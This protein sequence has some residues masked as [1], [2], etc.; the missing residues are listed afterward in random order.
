MDPFEK[1]ALAAKRAD[2][3]LETFMKAPAAGFALTDRFFSPSDNILALGD[4]L[5]FMRYLSEEKSLS[6]KIDFVYIDPPFFT[7]TGQMARVRLETGDANPKLL[8]RIAY[9]DSSSR[10]LE[11]YLTDLA[12]RLELIRDL[13]ADSGVVCVHL[14]WHAVH[15]VKLLM[16]G[17]FGSANFVNE[18]IWS[19][20]SG[21]FG[22]RGFAKKHDTILVYAKTKKYYFS[23]QKEKSYNRGFKP[24]RFKGVKEYEDETGWYTL[25]N[26]RDVFTI[27]MVPRS[28]PERTGYATQK[29]LKLLQL[30]MESFCPAEGIAA[31][32]YCGSGTRA[33]AAALSGRSFLCC[34]AAPAALVTSAARTAKCGVPFE[35]M[36]QKGFE[37]FGK[38]D[39]KIEMLPRQISLETEDP[40]ADCSLTLCERPVSELGLK[41]KA[42]ASLE[43]AVK[44]NPIALAEFAA[45]GSLEDGVFTAQKVFLPPKKGKR[46][47]IKTAPGC[48]AV[49]VWDKFG[50][51][52]LKCLG[53]T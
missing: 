2:A 39:I 50:G 36:V 34:D 45:S 19:Y 53:D 17:I 31:D 42:A 37:G 23:P 52:A 51:S 3:V 43:K 11:A 18:L 41:G 9:S 12:V 4:N 5:G 20:K 49:K 38:P 7:G 29:P 27:D 13:M 46:L 24:Y 6:G 25:V 21:G 14:D 30:L 33:E 8:S 22:S 44:A 26:R 28:S 16:D 1:L 15:Y 48:G 35:M 10:G 32:F 47:D 40:G